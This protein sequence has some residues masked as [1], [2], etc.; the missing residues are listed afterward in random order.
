[1]SFPKHLSKK[2]ESLN[3]EFQYRQLKILSHGIDFYSNDYLGF[4]RDSDSAIPFESALKSGASG[5]RLISGNNLEI[6]QLE[7]RI[8]KFHHAQA[9]LLYPSGYQA[10]IGLYQVIAQR[11]DTILFDEASHAS[12]RDG[13]RLSFANSQSFKHNDMDDLRLKIS[14]SNRPIYI[15]V[16]SLYSMDGDT[17]PLDELAKICEESSSHLIIDEAHALGV[18]GPNGEGLV[19][20]EN[21][22]RHCLARIYG[23]GKAAGCQGAAIVGDELLRDLLINYS[24]SFIFS[25]GLSPYLVALIDSAY[26]RL[27][28]SSNER[29]KLHFIIR[30]FNK[31]FQG[32]GLLTNETCESP[33][34]AL[35]A[36]GNEHVL[37][38]ASELE[39]AGLMVKGI[40]YPTV[41]RTKERIRISLHAFN[42][43]ED[44]DLL[45]FTVRKSL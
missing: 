42:T 13:I 1:M 15:V 18:F 23:F 9:A 32:Q 25:T 24:R 43:I 36:N 34:M 6:E 41:P 33:I 16:E 45:L 12:I 30:Y 31:V 27:E 35:K 38:Y 5:S 11:G 37:K 8:A 40:R 14:T 3:D 28:N 26:A 2:L 10:N 7:K 44:V 17:A 21:V 39:K 29:D 19:Y 20:S 22:L 4:N